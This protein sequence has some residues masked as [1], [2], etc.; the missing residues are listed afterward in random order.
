M[1]QI[2]LLAA[3]GWGLCLGSTTEV[4]RAQVPDECKP[5]ALNIPEAKY[6]CV[7]PDGRAMFRVIAPDAQK[8]SVRI[9]RGF[10]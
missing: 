5:S 2:F 9:G 4:C 3:I 6:P 8:V 10:D 1:K 7:Y